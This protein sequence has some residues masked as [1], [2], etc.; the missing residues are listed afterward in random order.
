[1]K[2][3]YLLITLIVINLSY[4]PKPSSL[5][6][7]KSKSPNIIVILIDDAGDGDFDFMGSK[8]L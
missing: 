4:S 3:F 6:N 5:I 7:D 1:M 2:I 8:D